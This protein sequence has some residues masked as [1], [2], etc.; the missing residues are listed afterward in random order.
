MVKPVEPGKEQDKLTD[1]PKQAEIQKKEAET[2][3]EEKKEEPIAKK[4]SLKKNPSEGNS[5]SGD[6]SNIAS[7][8]E[9]I[10]A[11]AKKLFAAATMEN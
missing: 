9:K 3:K 4:P 5:K 7:Q 8:K 10:K 2:R 11:V 6:G 1:V